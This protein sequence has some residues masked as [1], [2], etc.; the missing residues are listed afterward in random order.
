MLK[1]LIEGGMTIFTSSGKPIML[2]IIQ[3]QKYDNLHVITGTKGIMGKD[4]FCTASFVLYYNKIT[5]KP[6]SSYVGSISAFNGN[7]AIPIGTGNFSF[8]DFEFDIFDPINRKFK[9]GV[10]YSPRQGG[11]VT[12]LFKFE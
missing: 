3:Y 11:K 10:S 6:T 1:K 2:D 12:V 8:K 9:G 4:T 5:N 7:Q